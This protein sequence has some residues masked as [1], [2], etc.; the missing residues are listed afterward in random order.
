[1]K[2]FI[3][4]LIYIIAAIVI[5]AWFVLRAFGAIKIVEYI[6]ESSMNPWKAVCINISYK[7]IAGAILLILACFFYFILKLFKKI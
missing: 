1:M 5:V 7:I 4:K 3:V 6:V 2:N